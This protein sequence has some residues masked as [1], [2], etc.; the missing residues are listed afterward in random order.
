MEEADAE[1]QIQM[2]SW[3]RRQGAEGLGE[4]AGLGRWRRGRKDT[5]FLAGR[6]WAKAQGL[7]DEQC[8]GGLSV[9]AS[10]WPCHHSS[11]NDTGWHCC[12]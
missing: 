9:T 2:L 10:L 8:T 12:C 5:P 7:Q 6:A 11:R 3:G 1:C 4:E